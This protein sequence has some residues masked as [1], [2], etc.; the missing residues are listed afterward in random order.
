ME[1]SEIPENELGQ[2]K[3]DDGLLKFKTVLDYER[4]LEIKENVQDF[5]SM[6]SLLAESGVPGSEGYRVLEENGVLSDFQDSYLLELLDPNGM[7]MIDKYL[8]KLDFFSQTAYVTDN[9]EKRQA[10]IDEEYSDSDILTY[11]FEE[12]LLEILFGS[13][14][15][16]ENNIKTFEERARILSCPG[17]Y[18]PGSTFPPM[19]FNSNC[20]S[21]KCEW[22]SIYPEAGWEYKAEA[23]HAYQAAAIYFRLKT[24]IAHFKRNTTTSGGWSSEPDPNMNIV[25]WGNFTPKNRSTVTLS[26]CY[27][28]CQG[29]TPPP[30]N[31]EKVQK[32]H[33]EAGRRLT[34]YNLYGIFDVHLGGNHAASGY[35]EVFQLINIQE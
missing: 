25:Y 12:E 13:V 32:I 18:P 4:A 10:M 2:V 5:Y 16:Y 21:R 34:S 17:S 15:D 24:E 23:M 19:I 3:L 33:H 27:D 28:S 29:C 22:V 14:V 26:G 8:I 31:R 35:P 6:A 7:I 1:N 9:F 30:A 20:D 11:S